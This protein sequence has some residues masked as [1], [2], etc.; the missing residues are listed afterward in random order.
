[1]AKEF[2]DYN[3]HSG[4]TSWMD[5]EEDTGTAHI[6]YEQDIS[7]LVDR[8]KEL[9]NTGATDKGIKGEFWYYCTLP[10]IYQYEL[11]KRGRNP[12]GNHEEMMECLKVVNREWPWLKVTAKKHE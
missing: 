3:P 10:V 4:V 2:F 8:N 6:T 1:M 7:A 5:Y 11:I 9:A 12:Y